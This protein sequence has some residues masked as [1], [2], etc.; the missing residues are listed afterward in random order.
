[1][2]EL[3]E[4][5]YRNYDTARFAGASYHVLRK[6]GLDTSF[7][8]QY[9]DIQ[10][11]QL[12]LNAYDQKVSFYSKTLTFVL[13][14]VFAF[15]IFVF[16]FR[17]LQYYGSALVLSTH[18]LTFNLLFSAVMLC[19]NYGPKVWFGS[20]RF[21]VLPYKALEA[22]LYNSQLEAFS[23]AVFGLY[24]GFQALHVIAWGA[25]LFLAF[26]QLFNFH[27][28]K[29]LLLSYLFSRLFVIITFSLYKKFLIAITI[30]TM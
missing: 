10:K 14:P 19:I 11:R 2:S 24:N 4:K 22:V 25:W 17:R 29:S 28:T 7:H 16:L 3:A 1:M 9:S 8:Q 13:I 30:L 15:I 5:K 21:S 27:W 23:M 6:Y 12:F 26:R 18:F 20:D